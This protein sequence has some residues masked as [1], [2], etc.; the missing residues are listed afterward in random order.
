MSTP[1]RNPHQLKIKFLSLSAEERLIRHEEVKVNRRMKKLV[2]SKDKAMAWERQSTKYWDLR[3]HRITVVRPEARATH[4]ARAFLCGHEYSKIE[5]FRYSRPDWTR[6]GELVH[7]YAIG[8]R[9]VVAQQLEEWIQ[10][11]EAK[12]RANMT[13]RGKQVV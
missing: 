5:E 1:K 11:G 12:T 4:L 2:L 7:K 3:S 10:T 6:V 9:Q 8:N 13:A